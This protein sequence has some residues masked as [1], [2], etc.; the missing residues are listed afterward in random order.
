MTMLTKG[1][2]IVVSTILFIIVIIYWCYKLCFAY[3]IWENIFFCCRHDID[4]FS[5]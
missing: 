2:I 4:L 5:L 3:F 1:I